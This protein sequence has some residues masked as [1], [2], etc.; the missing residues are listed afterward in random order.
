[1][2]RSP[3]TQINNLFHWHFENLMV[4]FFITVVFSSAKIRT[5]S[6]LEATAYTSTSA[7]SNRRHTGQRSKG[8]VKMDIN[9]SLQM[10]WLLR[11]TNTSSIKGLG[12]NQQKEWTHCL[13]CHLSGAT[14]PWPHGLRETIAGVDISRNYGTPRV[15]C[16]QVFQQNSQK[17][18]CV[19]RRSPLDGTTKFLHV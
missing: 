18:E 1:M 7:W 8:L 17:S 10:A 9:P 16:W 19:L 12:K 4:S 14:Q 13:Q 5:V 6:K 11:Q 3:D 15:T 2:K